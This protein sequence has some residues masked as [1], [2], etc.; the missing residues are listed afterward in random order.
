MTTQIL[1]EEMVDEQS[2]TSDG[3]LVA[4]GPVALLAGVPGQPGLPADYLAQATQLVANIGGPEEAL[5]LVHEANSASGVVD[6]VRGGG[7]SLIR[8]NHWYEPHDTFAEFCQ[9]ECKFTER[10]GEYLIR[11]YRLVAQSGVPLYQ[12]QDV[13][14]TNLRVLAAKV[15]PQHLAEWIPKA[16]ELSGDGLKQALVEAQTGASHNVTK[17]MVIPVK[18]YPDEWKNMK[19]AI[20][21]AKEDEDVKYDHQALEGICVAYMNDPAVA[22]AAKVATVKHACRRVLE[23]HEGDAAA[24]VTDVLGQVEEVFVGWKFHAEPPADGKG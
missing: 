21:Q 10:K 22:Q 4:V 16:K 5:A 15:D 13:G 19:I 23:K 3:A 12:L 14:L 7:L 24:A 11:I 6:I 18:V 1:V 8:E 2:S 9:H 20:G 17:K